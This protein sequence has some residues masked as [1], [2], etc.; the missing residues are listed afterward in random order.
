MRLCLQLIVLW[1]LGASHSHA[2]DKPW[3]IKTNLPLWAITTPNLCVEYQMATK[4]SLSLSAYKGEFV[5]ISETAVQGVNLAYRNYFNKQSDDLRGFYVSPGLAYFAERWNNRFPYTFGVRTDVGVQHIFES[6]II[7][8]I[9]A[10]IYWQI[11]EEPWRNE[12]DGGL[13]SVWQ[14]QP[15]LRA[16]L[17]VGYRF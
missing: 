6:N 15:L 8:D 1:T 5:F 14:F 2:Q 12:E 10:G 11:L 7:I 9:G 17:S 16:N 4:Q 3:H 13:S